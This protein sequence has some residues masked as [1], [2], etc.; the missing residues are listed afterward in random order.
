DVAVGLGWLAGVDAPENLRRPWTSTSV[1]EFWRRWHASLTDWL[2]D[3]LYVP[4][5]GAQHAAVRN[6]LLVF[7]ASVAWYV[8]AAVK[9]F[10]Y[11]ADPPAAWQGLALCGLLN[12]AAVAGAH[13]LAR[14]PAP[15]ATPG[16]FGRAWRVAGTVV[17]VSLAWL[18]V[19]MPALLS[20]LPD[21]GAIYL[22]L[23]FF[24]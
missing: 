11:T 20:R 9:V 19:A 16:P 4:L 1:A 17:F 24:R 5:G 23:F 7:L 3:Y 6:V 15:A 10:G 14:Q 12:A 8:W 2:R 18:P 21:L 13:A 22:R